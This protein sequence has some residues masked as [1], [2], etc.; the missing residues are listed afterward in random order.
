MQYQRMNNYLKQNNVSVAYKDIDKVSQKDFAKIRMMGLGAS[1]SA[2]ILDLYPSSFGKSEHDLFIEKS[3]G[4][5]DTSIG[6]KGS[7]RKGRL[8]EPY[9]LQQAALLLGTEIIKPKDMYSLNG[10]GLTTNF[11]G[12]TEDFI[13]VEAK[14]CTMYGLKNYDWGL[15]YL[16]ESYLENGTMEPSIGVDIGPCNESSD[17]KDRATYFGIPAYYYSQIQQ[18]ML[19]LNA[20]YGYLAVL[21]DKDFLVYIFKVYRDDNLL[22]DLQIKGKF[23]WVKVIA[24]REIIQK[25][26]AKGN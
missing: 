6:I 21:N 10:S 13:P 3:T 24:R 4:T 18:Q 12:V 1:D 8:L 14:V 5:Y 20:P 9:I 7:V 2:T 23:I 22:R 16:K 15:C 17:Y 11:D 25:N 19:F 26:K